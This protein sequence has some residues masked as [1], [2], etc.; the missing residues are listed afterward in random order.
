MVWGGHFVKD[1]K[2]PA[3]CQVKG[4]F[5]VRGKNM[6]TGP[7]MA[8]VCVFEGIKKAFWTEFRQ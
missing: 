4:S 3:M 2:S 1:E 5:L 6:H 8:H 7:K